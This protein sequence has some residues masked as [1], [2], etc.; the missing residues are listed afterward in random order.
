MEMNER[1]KAVRKELKLTQDDFVKKL[2]ITRQYSS[3]LESGVREPSE[4][5]ILAICREYNVDYVW[6]KT[7]DG[8]MFEEPTIESDMS[9][10]DDVMSGD[11]EFAKSFF[12]AFARYDAG[13]WK[14]LRATLQA[15]LDEAAEN[16]NKKNKPR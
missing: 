3:L 5:V 9:L 1:I 6:L 12:R 4:Q 13:E 2:G 11:D 16:E 10:I 15:V 14:K 8:E 7:G